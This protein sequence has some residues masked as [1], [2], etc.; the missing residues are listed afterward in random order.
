MIKEEHIDYML[1]FCNI[2]YCSICFAKKLEAVLAKTLSF[3]DSW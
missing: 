1:F 3:S 2:N